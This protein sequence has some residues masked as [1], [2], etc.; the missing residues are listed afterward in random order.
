MTHFTL[1]IAGS[2]AR[3]NRSNRRSLSSRVLSATISVAP[4]LVTAQTGGEKALLYP[5]GERRRLTSHRSRR[6]GGPQAR[7]P[8][9]LGSPSRNAASRLS[10]TH[11]SQRRQTACRVGFGTGAPSR[12]SARR[13]A[14]GK[15]RAPMA[16]TIIFVEQLENQRKPELSRAYRPRCRERRTTRSTARSRGHYVWNSTIRKNHS[17]RDDRCT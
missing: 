10:H 1:C 5:Y 3:T 15:R 9:R 6:G 11:Q 4:A 2:I 8:S 17:N 7:R 16:P 14:D 13:W 12:L